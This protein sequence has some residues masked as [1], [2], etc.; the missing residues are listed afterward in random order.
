MRGMVFRRWESE[1]KKE[2]RG[3]EQRGP[4]KRGWKA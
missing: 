4:E 1:Q 2:D 3:E